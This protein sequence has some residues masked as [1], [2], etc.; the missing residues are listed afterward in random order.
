VGLGHHLCCN[1][2]AAGLLKYNK[3]EHMWLVFPPCRYPVVEYAMVH[4][5]IVRREQ[6]RVIEARLVGCNRRWRCHDFMPNDRR[7]AVEL[8]AEEQSSRDWQVE[9]NHLAAESRYRVEPG[10]SCRLPSIAAGE[11]NFR[12][13]SRCL[14]LVANDG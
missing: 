13:R 10:L 4:V 9:H 2:V 14:T 3:Y 5:K 11:F 7:S 6:L 8:A 1:R 12:E